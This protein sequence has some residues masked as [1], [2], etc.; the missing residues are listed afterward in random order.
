MGI[1][2]TGG[3]RVFDAEPVGFIFIWWVKRARYE[4]GAFGRLA[5]SPP[6]EYNSA[7]PQVLRLLKGLLALLKAAGVRTHK[8]DALGELRMLAPISI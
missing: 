4:D 2:Y 7:L 8:L 5:S 1:V 3:D 6:A